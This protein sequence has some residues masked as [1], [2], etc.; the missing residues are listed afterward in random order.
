MR[1]LL[2]AFSLQAAAGPTLA[3]ISP[4]DAD[5]ILFEHVNRQGAT[6]TAQAE[7]KD[8]FSPKL[9]EWWQDRA[10]SVWVRQGFVLEAYLEPGFQGQRVDLNAD[11]PGLSSADNGYVMNLDALG[12]N[13]QLSS[14]RCRRL[15]ETKILE[16]GTLQWIE[17][18]KYFW[19]S[20]GNHPNHK[21][22]ELITEGTDLIVRVLA[23]NTYGTNRQ[24]F[25]LNLTTSKL[26]ALFTVSGY[27]EGEA[28]F[29]LNLATARPDFKM[30]LSEAIAAISSVAEGYTTYPPVVEPPK[31]ELQSLIAYLQTFTR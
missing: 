5:C 27:A 17:G 1:H 6:W 15:G 19:L 28:N 12:V 7:G 8:P 22:V 25:E 3:D 31:P 14:Y 16:R 23:D 11:V 2:F 24:S 26:R 10:S 30:M 4:R 29:D 21:S 13:D 18:A 20:G 9:T